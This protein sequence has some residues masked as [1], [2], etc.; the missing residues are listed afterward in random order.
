[1]GHCDKDGIIVRYDKAKNDFVK[2][3]INKG[4]KTMF[5]PKEKGYYEKMRK[6][7]IENGGKT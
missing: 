5:K 6:A 3:N 7:D 4:I 1:M 2:A